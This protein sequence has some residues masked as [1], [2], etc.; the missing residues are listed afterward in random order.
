MSNVFLYLLDA[1]HVTG[2]QSDGLT[3]EQLKQHIENW[4]SKL[5]VTVKYDPSEAVKQLE[6]L[7]L[8]V[9]KLRGTN[10]KSHHNIA[11]SCQ[12]QVTYLSRI[13]SNNNNLV[14]CT[15]IFN[16][17]QNMDMAR[18]KSFTVTQVNKETL[19]Q[20]FDVASSTSYGCMK[21]YEQ[22]RDK[23]HHDY[24]VRAGMEHLHFCS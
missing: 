24:N 12:V 3:A 17:C 15:P 5:Q 10:H 14:T 19:M 1:S 2:L 6:N 21:M 11:T 9:T 13:A 7:G 16:N 18:W 23:F 4:M 22:K 20:S 8:L